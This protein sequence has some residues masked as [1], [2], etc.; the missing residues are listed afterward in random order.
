MNKGAAYWMDLK[1]FDEKDPV[2]LAKVQ[3]G[4]TNFV[5]ILTEKEIP[6]EYATTGD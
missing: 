4:I 5:R 2:F 6:V 1:Q 3:K